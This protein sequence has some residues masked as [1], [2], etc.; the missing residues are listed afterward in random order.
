MCRNEL[1]HADV[2]CLPAAWT[3][4]GER[5]AREVGEAAAHDGREALSVADVVPHGPCPARSCPNRTKLELGHRSGQ[6][7]DSGDIRFQA[8][9]SRDLAR[10]VDNFDRP[11][12]GEDFGDE[13]EDSGD[14]HAGC[15]K[16]NSLLY[17]AEKSY[18]EDS[19]DYT[20]RANKN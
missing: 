13:S 4:D 19:G 10:A 12:G 5:P 9:S 16:H 15:A 3:A 1:L 17:T 6:D 18:P 8:P 20:T 2:R 11:Q 7:E 14:R